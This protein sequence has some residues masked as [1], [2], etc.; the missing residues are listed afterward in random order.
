MIFEIDAASNRGIDDVRAIRDGVNVLPLESAR[1]VYI[2]DEVHMLTKEA[3]NALLK[4]LEE[5]P[6]HVVFILATTEMEKLPE[7]IISR[8]QTFIFRTPSREI[9][10]KVVTSVA[11]KEGV[12]SIEPG[13]ADLI[14]ILG[15]GSF[16][17]TLGVLQKVMSGAGAGTGRDG[18]QGAG[19]AG[20]RNGTTI[21]QTLVEAIAGAPKSSLVHAFVEAVAHKDIA[22]A[23]STL[24]TV[25]ETNLDMAVFLDL[26]LERARFILL[27]RYAQSPIKNRVSEDDYGF[28][29]KLAQDKTAHINARTLTELLRASDDVARAHIPRLPI[30]L[31]V[32]KVCGE[33]I[34]KN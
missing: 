23:F 27:E 17:D 2:I 13:A 34:A 29:S 31:V 22:K 33:D 24:D 4:T 15:D 26:V 28:I 25:E 16:R 10:R 7:T 5:P 3:F 30:E 8:C 11:K 1:K 14:A 20:E 6:K 18:G 9:L 32:I 19:K 12:E 21:T